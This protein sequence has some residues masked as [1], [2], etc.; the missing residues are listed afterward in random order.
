MELAIETH[1]LS[2]TYRGKIHALKPLDLR[3]PGGSCFGLLGPN[4]AGKSTLVKTLL[5]IVHATSGEA[6]LLGQDFRS[7]ESRRSVGY[8]PEGHRFPRY[9]TGRG[10]CEYFGKLSGLHGAALKHEIDEKVH[11]V[12][13]SEWANQKIARYSKGMAQRIGI[14]Q[15]LLGNPKLVFLDEPTDGVDPIGRR[16][17]R[18]VI[19]AVTSKG[20]TVFLNSHLLQEVET[21]CDSVAI[22]H[23][24]ALLRQGAVDEVTRALTTKAGVQL[25][26]DCGQL[27]PALWKILA[28]QGAVAI[29]GRK[30][31]ITLANEDDISRVID[32]LRGAGV[33]VYE[34]RR[35]HAGLEDAFVSLVTAQGGGVGA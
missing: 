35:E 9:L 22:M 24:G 21:I 18:E 11:I 14:A 23:K 15:A 25:S 17:I 1:A 31:G 2:K 13:M 28:Q 12:G 7:P 3:V 6:K 4:G 8:L 27:P 29:G 26:I 30:F 5:S 10:A 34:V 16:D 32:N 19:K 20:T 33:P